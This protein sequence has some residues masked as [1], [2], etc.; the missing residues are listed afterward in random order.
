VD[1]P[2]QNWILGLYCQLAKYGNRV[3]L[4]RPECNKSTI[5]P[6]TIM[7][8]VSLKEKFLIHKV[9]Q[10][11]D[12][13]AYGELYDFY[14]NR[15]FRF[16]LFKVGSKEVAED[17]TSQVFL[18]TWEYINDSSKKIG[19]FNA[20]L[21]K[22]ARNLV[23]DHYRQK[24]REFVGTD[25]DQFKNIKDKRDIKGETDVRLDVANIEKHLSKLKDVYREVVILK[26]IEEFSTV[27]MSEIM[28][29]TKGNIRILVH[30]ALKA[31]KQLT[32]QEE[33]GKINK[34]E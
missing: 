31:L 6:S 26:Y 22:I 15:I 1:Y 18:K 29:K 10:S 8:K 4:K 25:E 7:K 30:R 20:L 33:K 17:I 23:I 27:E 13:E 3:A 9:R 2:L 5:N 28:G 24:S 34:K 32:E 12:A 14:V 11:K 16:I 19:N 21:Y